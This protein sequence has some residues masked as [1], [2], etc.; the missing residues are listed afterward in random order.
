LAHKTTV[1]NAKLMAMSHFNFALQNAT[2]NVVSA[3]L[4]EFSVSAGAVVHVEQILLRK[5]S[6][7]SAQ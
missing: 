4:A 6:L 3:L 2:Q 1:G 7:G 5:V